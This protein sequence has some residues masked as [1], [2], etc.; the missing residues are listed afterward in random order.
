MGLARR[1]QFFRDYR[2]FSGGHLKVWHYF[3]HAITSGRWCVRIAFSPESSHDA[4]N[5]WL[6]AG[7]DWIGSFDPGSVDALFVEGMDWERVLESPWKEF[8]GPRINL[9]QGL[10]H[11]R[12]DNPR[13]QF[14]RQ[15]AVRI[16]VSPEVAEA[17]RET[18]Q[19]NGPIHVIPNGLDMA[20]WERSPKSEGGVDVFIAGLKNPAMSSALSEELSCRGYSV[21]LAVDAVPRN[22]FLGRM[23]R[24]RVAV[25]F[26]NAPEGEGFYLPALEA[27]ALGA[28][29]VCPDCVG[30]RSFCLD[31]ANSF[32]P[33]YDLG[34]IRTA[35]LE[36]LLLSDAE[37]GRLLAQASRTARRHSVEDERRLFLE[38]LDE[39]VDATWHTARP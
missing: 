38:I 21:D 24:A 36:A 9:I 28:V 20:V 29:V 3:Q 30:N 7:T 37:R 11:A 33:R 34:A 6:E 18:R 27:M 16:C 25:F 19:V 32:R 14:L 8:E 22:R 2:E 39:A 10:R 26:P 4:S 12:S 17:L 31:G 13:Y 35:T 15:R 1:L 5:P 23:A